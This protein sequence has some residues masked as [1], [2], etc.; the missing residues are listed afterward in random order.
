[1]LNQGPLPRDWFVMPFLN[2]SSNE[3]IGFN[4]QKPEELLLEKFIKASSNENDIVLD[5]FSGSATTLATAHKLKRR[6]IGIEQMNYINEISIP[7]LQEV[8]RGVKME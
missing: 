3:R 4:T 6:Y 7:R 2:Q 5:F 1:M 8:I